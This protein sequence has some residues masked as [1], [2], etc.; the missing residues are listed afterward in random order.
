[1]NTDPYIRNLLKKH[2]LNTCTKAEKEILVSF[3]NNQSEFSTYD[4][5]S[6]EEINNLSVNELSEIDEKASF[7]IYENIRGGYDK[8]R[9]SLVSQSKK[10][11]FIIKSLS[12]A[13]LFISFIAVGV[14]Y[15][16]NYFSNTLNLDQELVPK[17]SIT[18]QLDNGAIKI[19]DTKESQELVNEEGNV[20]GKQVKSSI[21][22]SNA[23]KTNELTYNILSIPYGKTFQLLLSDGT[24][25]YLNAGTSIKY[26]IK[27]LEGYSREVFLEGEAY[28]DVATDKEHLFVVNNNGLNVEVYGTK[29][30]VS[31]YPEDTITDVVLVE[32]SVSM[33]KTDDITEL[34]KSDKVLLIP[35]MKGSFNKKDKQIDTKPVITSIYTSWIH[36]ELVF[37]DMTF[38]NILKKLERHYNVSI[39]INDKV[40]ANEIFNA[41]FKDVPIQR[42]LEYLNMTY[43]I[44]FVIDNNHI[45][46]Q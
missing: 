43:N 37:R 21:A 22:Y 5:P 20:V 9:K 7:R 12:I 14:L 32:G 36:G 15:Q 25:V 19:I 29:F 31:T 10:K 34:N 28:F 39:T 40:L 8:K 6:V 41:S 17:T 2:A 42:V 27:F 13:A 16:N 24:K 33:Y 35:G 4:M 46:I 18:L 3:F 11:R 38:E 45:T 30:N 26:P 1:M 23:L 44:D